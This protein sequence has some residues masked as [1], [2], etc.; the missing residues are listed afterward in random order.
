MAKLTNKQQAFI[1]FYFTCGFNATE[2]ARRAG[3]AFPNVEGP[4]NLVNPSI[5]DEI[6]RRMDEYAMPANE[7]LARL[8]EMA[9]GTMY[10]FLDEHGTIDLNIA[11]ERGRLHLV[12]SR[13]TT[14]KGERIELYDAQAALVQLGKAHGLFVDRQEV[15]GANGEEVKLRLFT[16]ALERAYDDDTAG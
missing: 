14:D 9:R 1:D 11:R 10:D 16:T 6:S 8:A 5:K 3:Y 12:K 4:K 15:T 2:A 7:V 13:S